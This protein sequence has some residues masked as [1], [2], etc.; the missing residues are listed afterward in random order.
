MT[1]DELQSA[2]DKLHGELARTAE[3]DEATRQRL[4]GL[5]GDIQRLVGP[6][7]SESAATPAAE[8]P[9]TSTLEGMVAD[10][11][12]RHP[13]LTSTVQQLVDRLSEIGI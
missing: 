5:I 3:V 1:A 11:E 4:K 13:Q 10:F 6:A 8:K 7:E 9:L 2:L 12:A